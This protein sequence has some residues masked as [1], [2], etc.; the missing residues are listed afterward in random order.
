MPL[1]VYIDPYGHIYKDPPPEGWETPVHRFVRE[2]TK[3]KYTERHIYQLIQVH[4][5][6]RVLCRAFS[7]MNG[8]DDGYKHLSN[9]DTMIKDI[10]SDDEIK[11]LKISIGDQMCIDEYSKALLLDEVQ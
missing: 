10:F 6:A 5:Y 9:I 3:G 7:D 4:N 11:D 2:E 1:E 8:G